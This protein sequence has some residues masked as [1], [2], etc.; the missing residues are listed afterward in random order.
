MATQGRRG[1]SRRR[2]GTDDTA[3]APPAAIEPIQE[4][5]IPPAAALTADDAELAD[6][7]TVAIGGGRGGR[8]LRRSLPGAIAGTL[9]IVGIAF[10]AAGPGGAFGPR[11]DA[12]RDVAVEGAG[13]GSS[14]GDGWVDGNGDAPGDVETDETS[15]GDDADEGTEGSE[16]DETDA[17][18]SVE[19][20]DGDDA[21][22]ETPAKPEPEKTPKPEPK[23]EPAPVEHIGIFL[24]IKDDHPVIEWGSCAGLDFDYYKVVRSKDSTVTWP[25]GENDALVA[26]VERGGNRRAGDK[27]AP[28][29]RKVWYRVFCVRKTDGGYKVLNSSAAR[30]IGVPAEAPPPDPISLA[31][32]AGLTEEGKV[33][34]GWSACEVDGFAFYKIVRSTWNEH[35]SYLPWTDGTEVIGVIEDMHVTQL[36]DGAP[37]PGQTAFYRVQ[38]IGFSGDHK[39]LLGQ[40]DVVSVTAP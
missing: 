20:T 22:D 25:A 18:E 2:R 3:A 15:D 11:T 13:D 4:E 17:D 14:G 24:A 9:L 23:P 8:S 36:L 19:E 6:D 39:V 1:S 32:E 5:S 37:D 30:G 31:L 7:R 35:P 21:V 16:V 40:S 28:H 34:L 33:A 27:D 26:V 29:G 38:C 12:S 10:G